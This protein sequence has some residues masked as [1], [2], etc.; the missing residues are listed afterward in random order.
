MRGTQTYTIITV[1]NQQF[2]AKW[3]NPTILPMYIKFTIQPTRP[4]IVFDT[5]AIEDYML[6]R[7]AFKIGEGA[8]TATATALA[9]EAIDANGGNGYATSVL[10]S[11]DQTN[12]VEYIA[13]A[14]ATKLSPA[15]VIITV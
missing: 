11:T 2:I 14:V 3:D 4:G 10:I 6:A 15:D 1:S 5:Q 12:W 9:Q 13:P 7:E 8:D